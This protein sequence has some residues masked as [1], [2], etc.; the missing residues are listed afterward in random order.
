M[1]HLFAVAVVDF[2]ATGRYLALADAP[3]LLELGRIIAVLFK[4][5]LCVGERE[6]CLV[7]FSRSDPAVS[8]D[9]AADVP[10]SLCGG[11]LVAV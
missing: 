11:L 4:Q 8:D 9:E 3:L 7:L 5:P 1:E 10:W 6:V 2:V